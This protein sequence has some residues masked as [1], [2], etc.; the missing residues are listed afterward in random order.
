MHTYK[1]IKLKSACFAR[2]F[3][4]LKL[5]LA[6][7]YLFDTDTLSLARSLSLSHTHSSASQVHATCVS[8]VIGSAAVDFISYLQVSLP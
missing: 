2:C 5:M 7:I 4:V 6:R 1:Y 3:S 8:D